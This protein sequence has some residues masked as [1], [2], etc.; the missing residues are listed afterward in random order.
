MRI[1]VIGN[2]LNGKGVFVNALASF[3]SGVTTISTS[4]YLV[5]RLSIMKG[6][7]EEH[8]LQNKEE[9]RPE[10]IELGNK[11]CDV[12]PG[13]LVSI[14]LWASNT[15]Y[16][17]VDGVRR[18]CEFDRVKDLFDL[19]IWVER[20]SQEI[21]YD[22]CELKSNHADMLVMNDGTIDNLI[23]Q[24]HKIAVSLKEVEGE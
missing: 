22:N 13:C 1:L 14:C 6:V 15:Q 11:M 4:N 18:T 19:T 24:A 9:Y 3:L 7:T 23:G 20:P 17:I 16:T 5:Y 12:D 21:G 10:L 2:K 8:I